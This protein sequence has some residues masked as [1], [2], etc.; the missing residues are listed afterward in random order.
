MIDADA[1]HVDDGAFVPDRLVEGI[2]QALVDQID[3]GLVPGDDLLGLED[4][5]LA[6]VGIGLGALGRGDLVIGGIIVADKIVA[7][8]RRARIEQVIDQIVR[9][10][11]ARGAR[12]SAS[13]SCPTCRAATR[14]GPTSAPRASPGS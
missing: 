14:R 6:F 13:R 5:E 10:G 12:P 8:G 11:A 1:R 3:D 7:I 4:E 9:I 2:D